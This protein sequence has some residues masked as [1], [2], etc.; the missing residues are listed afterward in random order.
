[1]ECSRPFDKLSKENKTIFHLGDFKINLLNYDIHPPTN[2]FLDSLS[3]H[4][5]LPHILQP[6]NS[7]TLIDIF[8]NM[9]VPNIISGNLIASISDHPPQFLAARNIFFNAS[10]PISNIMK[11][12]GQDLIKKILYLIISQLTGITF[13]FHLT[14]TMK[15]PVKLFLKSLSLKV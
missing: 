15:N 11:E 6:S 14:Q 5:F 10:Y 4:N 13:C 9:V 7:K 3:S 12:T 2:G 8:S 1:M